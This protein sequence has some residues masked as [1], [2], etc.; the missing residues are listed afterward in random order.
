MMKDDSRNGLEFVVDE[1]EMEIWARLLRECVNIIGF[2]S[3]FQ[4]IKREGKGAF[5]TVYKV[6]NI[7]DGKIYA[8]KGFLKSQISVPH[9]KKSFTKEIEILRRLHHD[10]LLQLYGIYESANSVYIVTEFLKGKTLKE[11]FN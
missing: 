2:H 10:N 6:K 9:R 11:R 1:A 7:R 5:A 3:Y 4:G 8:A